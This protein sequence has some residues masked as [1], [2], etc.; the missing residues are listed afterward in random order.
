MARRTVA[1][2]TTAKYQRR[3]VLKY[4]AKRNKST[5]YPK[6]LIAQIKDRVAAISKMPFSFKEADFPNTRVSS[7]GHFSIFFRVE[8]QRIL[9]TAFWDN[10]NDPDKLEKIILDI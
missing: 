5:A 1:W 10:R 4:W 3:E 8:E 2:T 7:M 6:K 9:I